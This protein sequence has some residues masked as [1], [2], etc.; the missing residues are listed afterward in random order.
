MISVEGEVVSVPEV[1]GFIGAGQMGEP[2]VRRLL[3]AGHDV[4]L[5]ARRDEVRERLSEAGARLGDSVADVASAADILIVCLFSDAQLVDLAGGA[6][7]FLSNSRPDS[8][9]VS[10]TTGNVSTLEKLKAEYSQ[11]PRII[12]APVSGAATDIDAGKLTVLLGGDDDAV[13]RVEPIL[14]AYANPTIRT[15]G[16]G[17]ALNLKL[18]NNILFAANAQLVAA[19]VELGDR[20]GIGVEQLLSAIAVSSGRS[21]ALASVQLLGDIA[22]FSKVASPFL[23]KDV[24]ACVA[25]AEDAGVDLGRLR[26]VVDGGPLELSSGADHD[27]H[28]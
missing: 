28:G 11:G 7:G 23:R 16:L 5:Y 8:V 22:T 24:A 9:V 18:V 20:L 10:H 1:I 3:A 4:L 15:G 27:H 13:E 14:G 6:D 12:D 17:S 25:A 26:S 2:M 21:H 19:S